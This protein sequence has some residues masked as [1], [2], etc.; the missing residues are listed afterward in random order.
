VNTIWQ[1][2]KAGYADSTLKAYDSR[3]RQ[4]AKHVNLDVPDAVKAYVATRETWSNAFKESV[5]KSYDQYV[6]L[7]GLSWNRPFYQYSRRL[8]YIATT[9]QLNKIISN[10]RK[11]YALILSILRDA[12]LRP[13]E[14]Y[15][16]TLK[17]I[18]LE[19]G[20]ITAYS[21]K[22]GNPRLLKVKPSTLAML[23]EYVAENNFGL[24]L[25]I[26]PTPTA[27]RKAYCRT[28]RHL[29]KKLHEPDLMK[30]RLYDFRHY[31]A[32]MLYQ[33]TKDI[34][35]VKE[36]MGHKRIE[37]TLIYTHLIRFSDEEYVSAIARTVDEARKLV[38]AGFEYVT[39]IDDAK[40][41]KKRK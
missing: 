27:M 1:L 18:D 33:R 6:R 35:Y 36:Q 4:L 41:F 3:L 16:L 21:A 19:K 29:A 37:N 25:R 9:E 30:I 32:T 38:E 12:G 8:P 24:T 23:K 11:K 14:L 7:N 15:R 17:E 31:Y 40:I 22:N 5:C 28:R 20:N 10:C 39:E 26:F 2:K 34:L 13:I